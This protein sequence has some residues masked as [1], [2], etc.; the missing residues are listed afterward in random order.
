MSKHYSRRDFIKTTGMSAAALAALRHLP[1]Y[2]E[3]E[4]RPNIIFFIADDMRP[5]M[6]NFL[7]QGKGKNLTPN[8]D[9]L[10][11]EGVIMR[12]QYVVSPVCT[13]SRYNCLTG[14]YA[15]RARNK[16]FTDFTAKQ[17]GQTVIQWNSYL[18]EG[19]DTLARRMQRAGYKTGMV[20]KNH[21]VEVTDLYRF[22]SYDLDAR[23]PEVEAKLVE[24]AAQIKAQVKKAG[25]DYAESLYQDNPDFIGLTEVA[26]QNLDWIA[27]GGVDFI[28]QNKDEPFF[29]YFATTVPHGPT[30][31][32]RSWNANPLITANGYLDEPLDVLPPR[33]T[34]PE[35]IAAAGITE[36]DKENIL[37]LD[38]TLGALIAKVEEH[39]LDDNTIIFFFNDHGQEAKGTVY[40]G[41]VYNPSVIWR[42]G[43]FACGSE[44][45]TQVSNIDFAP[46][47]LDFVGAG[48]GSDA[49]DGKSFI[50]SLAGKKVASENSLY[51][52]L[53]FARGVLKGDWKYIA[54]RYPD[55]AQ[56][57]SLEDRRKVLDKYNEGRRF[58]RMVL[59]NEDDPSLPY[60]HLE[61]I[62]GGGHA[63][64]ETYGKKPGYFDLDQ[65]YNLAEDPQELTNLAKRSDYAERLTG[66]KKEMQKHLDKLPGKFVL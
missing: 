56:N 26:V 38:D 16:A 25:F 19:E 53:G 20:G 66:M 1:G 61:V 42:K 51:F 49:F 55:Y 44:C 9:R 36:K 14:R 4:K 57:M 31:A 30:E 50:G 35:R 59:V 47:I 37:W 8:L 52:E 32:E 64:H 33:H 23:Q 39:G 21:V 11:R 17:Q 41:G 27:Q 58:R 29:L 5:E 40:Q 13:P 22:P 24:N 3:T 48:Y 62:P 43:G 28:E 54:V 18:A 34:L 12:N 63:E 60:S 45:E 2:S 46:T 15:S 65:L 6:F 7:P 10:A